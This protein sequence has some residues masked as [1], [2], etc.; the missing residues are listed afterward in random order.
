MTRQVIYDHLV[1]EVEAELKEQG[2]AIRS[3]QIRAVLLAVSGF[4]SV[5]AEGMNSLEARVKA[6]EPPF[7]GE[8]DEE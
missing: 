1:E 3:R 8:G 6:I 7:V 2:A 5:L 4:L